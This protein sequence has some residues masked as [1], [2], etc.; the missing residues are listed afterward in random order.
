MPFKPTVDLPVQYVTDLSSSYLIGVGMVRPAAI[1][2]GRSEHDMV[3]IVTD[4]DT[5]DLLARILIREAESGEP[6][7][8]VDPAMLTTAALDMFTAAA[9]APLARHHE[10]RVGVVVDLPQDPHLGRRPEL[11]SSAD[12]DRADQQNVTPAAGIDI[13]VVQ[14]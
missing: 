2:A 13:S 11:V 3:A 5:A 7:D 14:P 1:V 9:L 4:P 8:R 10:G 12:L 6:T